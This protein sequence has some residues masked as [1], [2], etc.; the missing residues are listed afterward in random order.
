MRDE[1]DKKKYRF[2]PEI[3]DTSAHH[4]SF[5]ERQQMYQTSKNKNREKIVTKVEQQVRDECTFSP[6]LNSISKEYKIGIPAHIRLYEYL[7]N[8]N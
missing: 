2:V 5:T 6:K 8:F 3:N 1:I 7:H 4:Q